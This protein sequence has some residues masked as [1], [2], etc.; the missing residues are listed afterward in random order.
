MN[1]RDQKL[2]YI[3]IDNNFGFLLQLE[4]LNTISIRKSAK[5]LVGLYNIL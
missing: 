3:R 2:A 4:S 5:H 1:L